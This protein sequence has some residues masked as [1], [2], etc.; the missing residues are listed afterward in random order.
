MVSAAVYAA[1]AMLLAP[2]IFVAAEWIGHDNLPSRR[3]RLSYSVLAAVLWPVL[4]L[5]LVQFAMIL[6]VRRVVRARVMVGTPFTL[7][8]DESDTAQLSRL[9]VPY[10]SMG[11]PAT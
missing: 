4:A 6:A 5:G 1:T 8:L 9:A 7:D 10:V 2:T 11:T 3:R